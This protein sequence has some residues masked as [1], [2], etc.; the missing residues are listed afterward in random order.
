MSDKSK[1]KLSLRSVLDKIEKAADE[2]Y[3]GRVYENILA[4]F[5]ELEIAEQR[6]FLRGLINICLTFKTDITSERHHTVSAVA[7]TLPDVIVS[8]STP[9]IPVEVLSASPQTI[10]MNFP[11]DLDDAGTIDEYN[12]RELIRLKSWVVKKLVTGGFVIIA[13]VM[14][15]VAV[16]GDTVALKKTT[17]YVLEM[18]KTAIGF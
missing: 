6:V 13:V 1:E 10:P 18:L 2:Q 9:S 16:F 17:G 5:K 7:P 8:Q 14:A 3:D 11:T 15:Y 4:I 12:A